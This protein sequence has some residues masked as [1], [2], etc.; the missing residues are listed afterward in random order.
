[1]YEYEILDARR[2]RF[3]EKEMQKIEAAGDL[4][5]QTQKDIARG[6]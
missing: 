3:E 5:M 1:M 6:K 4:Y 2:R